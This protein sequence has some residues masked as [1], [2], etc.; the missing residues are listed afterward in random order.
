MRF[1]KFLLLTLSLFN[2]PKAEH[3]PFTYASRILA[4]F[5]TKV[6]DSIHVEIFELSP[7]NNAIITTKGRLRRS[8]PGLAIAISVDTF[9]QPEFQATMAQALAKMSQ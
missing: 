1:Q 6:E 9:K 7:L 3:V 4:F 5:F 2:K 8:F